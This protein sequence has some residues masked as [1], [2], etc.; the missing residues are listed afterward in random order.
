MNKFYYFSKHKLKFVEIENFK[1]KFIGIIL[2]AAVIISTVGIAGYYIINSFITSDSHI[3]SLEYENKTLN[4]KFKNL[5][6]LYKK[7]DTHLDSL[8]RLNNELRVAANL[9]PVADEEKLL[10]TGGSNFNFLNFSSMKISNINLDEI[11]NYVEN[12]ETRI[13]FE[14]SNYSEISNKLVENKKLFAAIPALKPCEGVFAEHGFGMRMHPILRTL[15][16]HEGI[17]IITALG[18][19]VHS[20]GEGLVTFVGYKGGFGLCIEIDHGFGYQTIYGH[21]SSSSVKIGQNVK[22]GQII[23]FTGNSG[24][25]SGPHLHYEVLHDGVK[26]DPM[27]FILDDLAIFDSK[28]LN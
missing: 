16:M 15:R 12:I 11:S 4:K 18:T 28:N 7:L 1:T 22:R 10:G 6:A 21:L 26:I 19:S 24:L 20:P 17:D 14:K 3:A 9:P 23:A 25:S 13:Q 2:C 27:N 5:L 8:T